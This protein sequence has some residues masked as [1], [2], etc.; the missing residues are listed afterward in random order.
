MFSGIPSLA[1]DIGA[2]VG[3]YSVALKRANTAIEIHAFEPVFLNINR[4]RANLSE[5]SN[6]IFVP[7][8]ISDNSSVATLFSDKPGSRLGSLYKRDLG[9]LGMSC[10][11]SEKVETITVQDYWRETLNGRTID[12]AKLDIEG[13]E[14]AAFNGFGDVRT[15]A[16]LSP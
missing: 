6:V 14:L 16:M 3:E 9:H 12:V 4:L 5:E 2:N 7:K 1:L 8:A 10:D 15:P 13:H 11:F